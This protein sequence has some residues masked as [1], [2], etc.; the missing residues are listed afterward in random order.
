LSV[1]E[2]LKLA[3]AQE[4]WGFI[5][6]PIPTGLSGEDLGITPQTLSY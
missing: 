1:Y 4:L 3:W 2:F 5:G 6:Q